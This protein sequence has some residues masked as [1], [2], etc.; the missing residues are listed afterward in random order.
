LSDPIIK[1]VYVR[2]CGVSN[3]KKYI[4]YLL[5]VLDDESVRKN[6]LDSIF[7]IIRNVHISDQEKEN[8]KK[9]IESRF[10]K[11]SPDELEIAGKIIQ[12]IY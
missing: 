12:T 9:E 8:I 4:N 11:M 10:T 6:A 7:S 3:N 2:A 5:S 1:D